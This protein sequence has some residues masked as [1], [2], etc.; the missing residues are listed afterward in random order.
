MEGRIRVLEDVAEAIAAFDD[1]AARSVYIKYLAE[2][3]DI[4]EAAVLEKIRQVAGKPRWAA[5]VGPAVVHR[6]AASSSLSVSEH[7]RIERQLVA[8][9]LQFPEILPEIRKQNIVRL[10][11]DPVLKTIGQDTLGEIPHSK[12]M[13]ET[14]RR[15]AADDV[16]RIKAR[17]SIQEENWEM[18]GCLN[19][20]RQFKTSK[21][22]GSSNDLV[23]KIRQAERDDDSDQLNELLKKKNIQAIKHDRE[24]TA[25]RNKSI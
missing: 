23:E 2:R 18:R 3:V 22:A 5:P 20:I 10:I 11:E 7:K 1:P 21:R 9:M 15:M 16:E 4:N 8:M 19:L 13:K 14:S 12:E 6:S 17:L 24:K 25:D